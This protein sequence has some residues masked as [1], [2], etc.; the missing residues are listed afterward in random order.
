M[1]EPFNTY[2]IDLDLQYVHELCKREG[3]TVSYQRG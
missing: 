3:E 2:T 1:T